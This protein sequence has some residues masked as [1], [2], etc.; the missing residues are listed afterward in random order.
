[1]HLVRPTPARRAPIRATTGS[2]RAAHASRASSPAAERRDN[3]SLAYEAMRGSIIAGE[4]PAGV[5]IVERTVAERLG[6][7]RTPVRSALHRLQQEGFVASSGRGADQ[8]LTVTPLTVDDGRELFLLVGHLEG[9]AARQAALLPRPARLALVRQ[10]KALNRTLAV[11]SRKRPGINRT[12]ELDEQFHRAYV[13][14]VAGPRVVALHRAVKP[15]IERYARF[16]VNTLLEELPISV[17]EHD[18][19]IRAIATG[20][21]RAAQSTVETN[22]HNAADRLART[23]AEHGEQTGWLVDHPRRRR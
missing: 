17:R 9:L 2:P 16:Y 20:G 18:A 12:Y 15:Q 21:A 3:V 14:G 5:R 6:I 10:L 11:E 22:W 19:I 7:S 4:L 1:L 13:E 8:R 23:I